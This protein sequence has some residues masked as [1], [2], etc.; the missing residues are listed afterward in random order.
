[1]IDFET[2]F[3]HWYDETMGANTDNPIHH[4]LKKNRDNFLNPPICGFNNDVWLS[5]FYPI[6]YE[7][8]CK[9]CLSTYTEEEII[10]LKQ[11][12]VIKRLKS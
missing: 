11:Y 5:K 9:N 4:K 7:N 10:D 6:K 3:G 8:I 2:E 12:L 1:M